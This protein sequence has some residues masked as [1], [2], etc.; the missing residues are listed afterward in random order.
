MKNLFLVIIGSIFLFSCQEKEYALDKTDLENLNPYGVEDSTIIKHSYL[1]FLNQDKYK[2]IL[3]EFPLGPKSENEEVIEKATLAKIN[4][5]TKLA[6][7]YGLELDPEQV[8]VDAVSGF[9]FQDSSNAIIRKLLTQKGNGDIEDVQSDF[10]FYLQNPRARMQNGNTPLPQTIRARMQQNP[11]WGYNV[12]GY[13]SEA[14][15][16]LGGGQL[17]DTAQVSSAK[18]WVIDSGIDS[19]HQDLIGLVN[20]RLS[21]SFV[22]GSPG[23]DS[24]GHGTAM[25]GVIAAIPKN[26]N[27]SKDTTLIGM[28]GVSPGAE[29]VSVKVFGK[30]SEASYS[31]ILRAL[32]YI[33]RNKA[34]QGDIVNLSLGNKIRNCHQYGLFSTI[35]R[36]AKNGIFFS[37]A[38]GNSFGPSSPVSAS[39]YLPACA[40]GENI[41]TIASFKL[42]YPTEEIKYSYY[43]NFGNPPIDWAIPGDYI[44]TTYP[45]NNKYAVME[46]TSLSAA[47]M[48]GLLHLTRGNLNTK[49]SIVDSLGT[50]YPVPE[51]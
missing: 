2:P 46:G 33:I 27:F 7:N 19:N 48:S 16:Y 31:D 17:R 25:A 43:S 18:V 49:T 44:F 29:L 37:I 50:S 14:V 5:I 41:F 38:A 13:T 22:D 45:E 35:W 3:D 40:E 6:K 9:Y 8:F 10:F 36:M 15:L 39:Q 32:N 1:V 20:M 47:L 51:R 21:K 23:N 26:I 34:K 24:W 30:N 11:S 4:S 12:A 28:T 42:D